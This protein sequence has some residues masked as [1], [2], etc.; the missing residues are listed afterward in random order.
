MLRFCVHQKFWTSSEK[1][2][3]FNPNQTHHKP[4]QRSLRHFF[5]TKEEKKFVQPVNSPPYLR[6]HLNSA[7]RA[8]PLVARHECLSQN[9][10]SLHAERHR[11]LG[12]RSTLELR[13]GTAGR[14]FRLHRLFEWVQNFVTNPWLAIIA[15]DNEMENKCKKILD[16]ITTWLVKLLIIYAY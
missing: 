8:F 15:S 3:N 6:S 10:F 13:E 16:P 9:A 14:W 12:F 7:R 1:K 4:P 5:T 2:K 11:T